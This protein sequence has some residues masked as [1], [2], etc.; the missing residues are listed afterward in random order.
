MVAS[1]SRCDIGFEGSAMIRELEKELLGPAL[2]RPVSKVPQARKLLPD[3]LL[4]PLW[5]KYKNKGKHI[6]P[7]CL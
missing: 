4:G 7:D 2:D 5:E 3:F 1:G 6:L